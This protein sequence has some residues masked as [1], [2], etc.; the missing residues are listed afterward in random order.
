MIANNTGKIEGKVMNYLGYNKTEQ[1]N[2]T[3]IVLVDHVKDGNKWKFTEKYSEENLVKFINDWVNGK[4]VAPTK[5]EDIPKEQNGP[6]YKLVNKS[7][8]KEVLENDLDV[9]VKFYSP[10]CGHCKRLAPAYE[11]MAKKFEGQKDKV[12]IAEFDMSSNDFELFPINGYP[13]L[14]FWKAGEKDKPIHYS[15]DRS[16]TD[17]TNFVL[18]NAKHQ[19]SNEKN[20]SK[21]DL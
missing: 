15:G 3:K 10:Y 4:Y 8:K 20:Q 19:I 2:S 14:I 16:V 17:L 18:K 5:S 12:R 9:F 21:G 7:F 13:T 6:I 11:E 1:D